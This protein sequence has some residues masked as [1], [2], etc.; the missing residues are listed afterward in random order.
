MFLISLKIKCRVYSPE[1]KRCLNE[2]LLPRRPLK[3]LKMA[4]DLL[5][6]KIWNLEQ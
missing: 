1:D 5:Y 2:K 3:A 6:T 4:L